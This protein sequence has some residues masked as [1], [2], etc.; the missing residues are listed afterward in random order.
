MAQLQKSDTATPRLQPTSHPNV[1]RQSDG[2]LF[3]QKKTNF[4]FFCFCSSNFITPSNTIMFGNK[5]IAGAIATVL[6]LAALVAADNVIALTPKTF[7]KVSKPR[8]SF[9]PW[10]FYFY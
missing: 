8:T 1:S 2:V 7:D 9:S 6:S 3:H 5:I 10:Q 4:P